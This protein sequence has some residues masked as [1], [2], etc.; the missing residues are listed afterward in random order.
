[1]RIFNRL[2]NAAGIPKIDLQGRKLDLHALRTT[3]ASRMQRNGVPLMQ[4]AR[5]LGHSDP[6]L[7]AVHYVDL[8]TEDLRGAIDGMPALGGGADDAIATREAR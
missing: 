4:A 8:D 6:K 2:L 1:M 7:T 5:I 3:A